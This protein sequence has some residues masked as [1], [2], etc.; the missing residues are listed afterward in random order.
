MDS[1]NWW[2]RRRKRRREKRKEKEEEETQ[3]WEEVK[4][5]G[6]EILEGLQKEV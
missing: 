3:S 4:G 6:R 1:T 5:Q 2:R